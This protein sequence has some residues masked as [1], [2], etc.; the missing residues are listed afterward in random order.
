M[1]VKMHFVALKKNHGELKNE[2]KTFVKYEND[3]PFF[4]F[5]QMQFVLV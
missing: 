1:A 5:I 4:I 2:N 3:T